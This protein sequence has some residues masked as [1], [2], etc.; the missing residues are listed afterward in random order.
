MVGGLK[1]LA[2]DSY[3]INYGIQSISLLDNISYFQ[4]IVFSLVAALIVP[5]FGGIFA[6]IAKN[7]IEGFAL[8]KT[9]G[10]I[11]MVPML[12][13]LP[14]FENGWQYI[15]GIAPNF[16]PMKA[17]LNVALGSANSWNLNYWIYMLIGG[18][19]Q[20][21]LSALALRIF[22]KKSTIK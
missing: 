20:I 8:M 4:I 1:L 6:S 2:R 5:F 18:V 19:F 17:L 16:W 12:C 13:L 10:L 9:G 3:V 21:L 11:I 7:K 22:I 15:L 14:A